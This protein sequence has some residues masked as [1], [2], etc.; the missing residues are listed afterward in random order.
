[1]LA[2][3]VASARKS[4]HVVLYLPDGDR[5]RK[6]GFFITP[7]GHR[8]G[9]FDLQN[10]SQEAC[11]AFLASHETDLEGVDVDQETMKKYFRD[12]QLERIPEYS[13]DSIGVVALLKHAVEENKHSPK[14]FSAVVDTMMS[15]TEKKFVMV[16]DEF[17]CYYDAGHYFHISYDAD[18]RDAI[19][20]KKINLFE[21]A[22][23]AMSLTTEKSEDGEDAIPLKIQN[24]AIVVGITESH[25]VPRHITDSLTSNAEETASD[26]AS[27]VVVEVPRFSDLEV[28]SILAN[29][30][31]TGIGNLRLDRGETVMNNQEVAYLRMVSG[32]VGQKLLDASIL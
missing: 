12:S 18:V 21:H 13:G 11:S 32:S 29:F 20:Y 6:N 31:A 28:D 10:L 27:M 14:C 24:G 23:G 17:N 1:M 3:I 26:D 19:P 22:L 5:L 16:F 8:E 2:S 30:E 7:N 25:A 4:G 9:M 15:Q